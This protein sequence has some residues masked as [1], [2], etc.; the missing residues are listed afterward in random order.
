[1]DS[2]EFGLVAAQQLFGI[3]DLHYGFWQAG[4]EPTAS[5]MKQA[6]KQYTTFL[7]D[8]VK[9]GVQSKADDRILDIGCGVGT[10]VDL[11]LQQGYQIDGLVPSEFMARMAREKIGKHR[12]SDSQIFLSTIENLDTA[13]YQNSYQT[14]YF[15][16]SYQYVNMDKTFQVLNSIVKPNGNVFIFDFFRRDGITE[17][18]PMGGGHLMQD[19]YDTLAKYPYKIQQEQDLTANM[20]PNLAVVNQVLVDKVIPVSQTFDKF[21]RSQYPIAYKLFKLLLKK[22]LKN[23]ERKY[24]K[25]RNQANFEKFKI[26]KLIHLIKQ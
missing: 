2:K 19:F 11:L 13:K 3:D 9:A 6:Q 21:M 22:K 10:I 8:L 25:E 7:T 24:S 23:F 14:V 17:R 26:Y 20:S 5:A 12:A 18:S 4:V 1:M 15:S 16:E